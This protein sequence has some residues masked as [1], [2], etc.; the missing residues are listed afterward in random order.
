MTSS[1]LRRRSL[2]TAACTVAVALAY[3][4]TT[5]PSATTTSS[6]TTTGAPTTPASETGVGP[7]PAA[8]AARGS[9]LFAR[10]PLAFE[11]NDGQFEG[12][13]RFVARGEGYEVALG[14]TGARLALV[15]AGVATRE[16]GV[17]FPGSRAAE[18]M[19]GTGALPGQT[20]YYRGND[21]GAWT[22]NVPSF[23]RVRATA[24]YDG[25][26]LEYYGRGRQLEYDFLVAPG[27][28]PSQIVVAFDGVEG[29]AV[30]AAG[31]LR[32]QVGARSIRQHR[33]VAYQMIGGGRRAV[34][35]DYRVLGS[36]QVTIAL[37]DYDREQPLVIDPVLAYSSYF[38]GNDDDQVRAIAVDGAGNIYLTGATS[39]TNFPTANAH[40]GTKR[41]TTAYTDAFVTKLNPAGTT[42]LFSTYLG[43]TST[44]NNAAETAGSIALD[45]LGNV[46]IAGDTVSA[47]F[48]TTANAFQPTYGGGANNPA[49]GFISKFTATGVLAYSTYFGGTDTDHINGL[50]IASDGDLT[51]SGRTRSNQLEAF[52]LVNAIDTT[53]SGPADAF[54][55][56]LEATGASLVFSTLIG[57]TGDEL[58]FYDSGHAIDGQDN[59]YISGLT[60]SVDYPTTPGALRTTRTNATNDG[61]VTKV[62][63][64]GQAILASTWFGGANGENLVSDV[65]I[66]P[67]GHVV[68]GGETNTTTGFPLVGAYQTSFQ[69]GIRDGF[70]AKLNATLTSVIFS[71][72]FGGN[73]RDV[74]RDIAVDADG[75]IHVVGTTGSTNLPL[76][77]PVQP[78]LASA[79]DALVARFGPAGALTF[80]SFLGSTQVNEGGMAVAATSTGQTIAGGWTAGTNFPRV[81][82]YQNVF[83]GGF[84]DGWLA[85]IGPGAD[86]G[87]TKGANRTTVEPGQQIGYTISVSNSGPDPATN[88]LV[89]DTLPSSLT[90]V[91]CA[92]NSGGVCSTN[93][94][95][96]TV[97]FATLPLNNSATITIWAR[98]N[99]QTAPSATIANT[100][101]LQTDVADSNPANNTSTNTVTVVASPRDGDTDAD[102]LPNGWESDYGL[103][104]LNNDAGA[105]PDGDGRTNQQELEQ[106]THPR[107][108]VI[109]YFAEG[110]TGSF[111]DTVIAVAN[112]GATRALVLTRFQR[113]DG[114]VIRRYQ[115]VE[116]HSRATIVVEQVAGMASASFSTLI[117]ADVPVVA[118]RTMS[119][120]SSGYG[121]HA[122][123]GTLT[124]AS[125]IWY[126]AEGAT[127]GGF[128]LFYLI[129]NP[130]DVATMVEVKF[131]RQAPRAPVVKQYAVGP[132]SRFTLH[133][134]AIPEL[135]ADDLS[136][137][138]RS[139]DGTP[140]V[141]ERAMYMSL[142]GQSFGAGHNSA[143]VTAPSTRWFFAEGATGS[144][145]D[146]FLL[147]ANPSA[148][149]AEVDLDFLLDNGTV[150]TKHYQIAANS[151]YTLSVKDADPRLR[152]AAVSTV[153]T[154]ANAVPI[155]VERAMWWPSPVWYEGHNS[156]GETT[157]GTK[158]GLA[159]GESGGER[160]KVTYIL[161]ANT[162]DF[163]GSARVTL[164]F[165]DGTTAER[166]IALRPKSRTNVP[167]DV[168]SFPTSAN[169]RYGAVI[170][171]L[172][173]DPAQIVVERAQYWNAN[174]VTWAA[175]TNA[176][177]TK[178][179]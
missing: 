166:V 79:N 14:A 46:Y 24:I 80:S 85:R 115:V 103:D 89:I 126:L 95:A 42:V 154:S 4:N 96:V 161:V 73:A 160:S 144:F 62:S 22:T 173:A 33:P 146:L 132:Q 32:L 37:G 6:S 39:S 150:V 29:V 13:V 82:P 128:D 23:G 41:G 45:A 113:E 83:Q 57:G 97:Q 28:D 149:A 1:T 78:T 151:R 112:P 159:E 145:F 108:F 147:L 86:L 129:Q 141:V 119:W 84:T 122:E 94:N 158:W 17:R 114:A 81:N 139:T 61:F 27:A 162:S 93:G 74:V 157:T 106:G 20:H 11:R 131:L 2:V 19:T 63:A 25:I 170:E 76:V 8:G 72:Y 104:P 105:D 51:F 43:G 110:A 18:A 125:S 102:G 156:P 65:A 100:A 117:E 12:R 164:L 30:D 50:A 59:I 137:V 143:G 178:L 55:A 70:V 69:G 123:R 60:T 171:S 68:I 7:A 179:Q 10:L 138:V 49:D 176:L 34:R 26:D 130:G 124:R 3:G 91:S 99:P 90:L 121:G 40:Q 107:G 136:A 168:A 127:H 21:P 165:E 155:F 31:D 71:T 109:T 77:Q 38:G 172:G 15:E 66:A 169:R 111:F 36:Q 87:I 135:A 67:T 64:N 174:G 48:P 101:F 44:E 177:G 16:V 53:L 167:V 134:D 56:R 92:A 35:A 142:P 9:N 54:V 75:T 140:I 120:D 116:A 58:S 118:D 153:V 163:A 98:V 5:R 47:D 88:V 152:D 133:V 52:P 148:E 175:G